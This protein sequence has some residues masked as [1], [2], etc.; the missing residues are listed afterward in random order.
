MDAL[1]ST[2]RPKLAALR[3]LPDDERARGA[4]R[5]RAELH[6]QVAALLTPDQKPRYERFIAESAGPGGAVAG[7]RG[8]IYVLKPDGRPQAV[9]VRLGISDGSVTELLAPR[10]A[11]GTTVIVGAPAPSVSRGPTGPRPPF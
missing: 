2:L 7:T 1:S 11:P 9:S 8:R 6:L 5:V 10:L 4:D 3:S